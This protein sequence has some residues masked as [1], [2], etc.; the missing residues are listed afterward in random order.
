M[1]KPR[2]G[3]VA[4]CAPR[5]A[6]R[7][8]SRRRA[9]VRIAVAQGASAPDRSQAATASASSSAADEVTTF[10]VRP[11]PLQYP[12]RGAYVKGS[13]E[14]L[15]LSACNAWLTRSERRSR[16]ACAATQSDVGPTS[17]EGNKN[18]LASGELRSPPIVATLS[19]HSRKAEFTLRGSPL[20]GCIGRPPNVL[21]VSRTAGPA[22]RSRSGT[23]VAADDVRRT[24]WRIA[25][26]VTP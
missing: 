17:W 23:A 15:S 6:A 21:G 13:H 1:P 4:T 9:A 2:G 16:H 7:V 3:P 10:K 24:E 22:C 20:S 25:N 11:K 8:G 18:A 5:S 14:E 12:N 19:R 26:A